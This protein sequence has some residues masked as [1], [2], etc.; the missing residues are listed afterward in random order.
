VRAISRLELKLF[1]VFLSGAR[2]ANGS[3]WSN[4]PPLLSCVGPHSLQVDISEPPKVIKVLN[5]AH[6]L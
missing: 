1:V 2:T 3:P 4:S 6:V 5:V